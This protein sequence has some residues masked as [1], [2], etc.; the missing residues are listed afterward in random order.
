MTDQGGRN[1]QGKFPGV[2]LRQLR[3]WATIQLHSL[4]AR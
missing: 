3:Q 1:S 2:L 4:F